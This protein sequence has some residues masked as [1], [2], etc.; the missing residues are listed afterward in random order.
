MNALTTNPLFQSGVLPFFITLIAALILRPLGGRW[1]G[2]GFALAFAASVYFIVGFQLM[3]FT[4]TRKIILLTGAA[5]L[6]GLLFDML[7]IKFQRV[8]PFVVAGLAAA[9]I[10]WLIWPVVKRLEGQEY[11]L[12][13]G[14]ASAYGIGLITGTESL[15]TQ[16]ERAATAALALG[17]GTSISA[18]LGASALLGQLGGIVA[19]SAGAFLLLF[20]MNRPSALS[21]SFTFPIAVTS[22]LVGIAAVIYAGLDAYTLIPLALIPLCARMPI[23]D[24]WHPVVKVITLCLYTLPLSGISIY[25]AWQVAGESLY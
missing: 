18:V 13:L 1:A 4:S 20:A 10:T 12:M 7:A 19:A 22:T 21:S 8:I 2:L 25:L 15:R 24:T 23:K 5:V 14:A 6:F 3:P 17:M 16:P 11:W 9:A